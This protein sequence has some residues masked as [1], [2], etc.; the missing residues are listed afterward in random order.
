VSY[1]VIISA[2]EK[3]GQWQKALQLFQS[4]ATPDACSYSAAISSCEESRHWQKALD[5]FG[6]MM[7]LAR[8]QPDL[9]S[10]ICLLDAVHDKASGAFYFEQALTAN[11]FPNLRKVTPSVID[12]HGLSEGAGQLAVRWWLATLV[13]P[14]LGRRAHKCTVITGYGKSRKEWRTTNVQAAV[15]RLLQDLQ[16][17]V[18]VLE[19]AG[20]LQLVLDEGDGARL[21]TSH[22]KE[23]CEEERAHRGKGTIG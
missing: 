9:V 15:F 1:N 5:L 18:R 3:G 8:I 14:Q 4:M 22:G 21:A 2:C 23:S 17:K 13:T 16:L 6:A 20:R 7:Q 10:Y 12:L 19:N 11:V